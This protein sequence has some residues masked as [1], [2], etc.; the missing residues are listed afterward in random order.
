MEKKQQIHFWY[1]IAAVLLML[2]I[3]SLYLQSTKLTAIP[4]PVMWLAGVFSP[5][6]KELRTTRYQFTS[7][8]VIDS[9]ATTATRCGS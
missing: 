5:L 6:I 3:Q 4:Y 1:V 8:F 7:P 9:S 2:F